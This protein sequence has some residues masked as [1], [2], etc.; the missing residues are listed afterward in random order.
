LK[1]LF[2]A[3]DP[4]F[5]ADA[6]NISAFALDLLFPSAT[7]TSGLVAGFDVF[8]FS[9]EALADQGTRLPVELTT[10]RLFSMGTMSLA[11]NLQS[12]VLHLLKL[13]RNIP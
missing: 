1:T 7:G 10:D 2:P 11:Q 4:V 5:L 12:G 8:Q 3:L 13:L 9:P 6:P